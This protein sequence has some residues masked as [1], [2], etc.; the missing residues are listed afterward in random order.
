MEQITTY[1]NFLVNKDFNFDQLTE[2]EHNFLNHYFFREYSMYEDNFDS[3]F[4]DINITFGFMKSVEGVNIDS[5]INFNFFVKWM[6][7]YSPSTFLWMICIYGIHPNKFRIEDV[8]SSYE[9]MK[10]E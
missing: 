1:N 8:I 5:L 6:K 7:K 4:N 9:Y 3:W 2:R 10:S